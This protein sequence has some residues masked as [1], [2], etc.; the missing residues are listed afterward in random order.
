[1]KAAESKAE[2]WLTDDLSGG[3]Q[4]SSGGIL[5]RERKVR[6]ACLGLIRVVEGMENGMQGKKEIAEMLRKQLDELQL[7]E[8]EQKKPVSRV[9]EAKIEKN[10]TKQHITP[11]LP[12]NKELLNASQLNKENYNASQRQVSPFKCRTKTVLTQLNEKLHKATTRHVTPSVLGSEKSLVLKQIDINETCADK[13][14]ASHM[15]ETSF[16]S[17][18]GPTSTASGLRSENYHH[19]R[20]ILNSPG[21]RVAARVRSPL[22]SPSRDAVRSAVDKLFSQVVGGREGSREPKRGNLT[23]NSDL[24]IMS[25]NQRGSR[26]C[27]QDQSSAAWYI[28]SPTSSKILGQ[29]ASHEHHNS[30]RGLGSPARSKTPMSPNSRGSFF[31]SK[32]TVEESTPI[33]IHL[34]R[35]EDG[36][37]PVIQI[38]SQQNHRVQIRMNDAVSPH[39]SRKN[40]S[41]QK[42]SVTPV[43]KPGTEG[44][45]RVEMGSGLKEKLSKL[46]SS[47]LLN[48]TSQKTIAI[49]LRD[50]KTIQGI[51]KG[52]DEY[53]LL[54]V[55]RSK[56]RAKLGSAKDKEVVATPCE[57]GM[58]TPRQQYGIKDPSKETLHHGSSLNNTQSG[59]K[60]QSRGLISAS[61]RQ[62]S[63]RKRRPRWRESLEEVQ[64]IESAQREISMKLGAMENIFTDLK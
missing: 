16:L 10:G 31:R 45:H 40:S 21:G 14:T 39:K 3:E 37:I 51:K 7:E 17:P 24:S 25:L 36:S 42:R 41:H 26:K 53:G 44:L 46:I 11:F 43:K 56:S 28:R 27:N 15:N 6:E 59:R 5:E 50:S 49:D 54:G 38:E 48:E 47:G 32:T 60:G 19:G 58:N 20:N 57:D 13:L 12:K 1:M 30:P 29:P 8:Y 64:E 18:R 33:T 9:C 2:R 22:Q 61:D 52:S 4:N 23:S 63:Q 35:A 34:T 55:M 62:S